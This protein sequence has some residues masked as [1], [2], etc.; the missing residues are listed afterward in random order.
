MYG[1]N[2]SRPA[3]L[4]S[5]SGEQGRARPHQLYVADNG[6]TES[7]RSEE[8]ADSHDPVE[9]QVGADLGVVSG[10][11]L[12][13]SGYVAAPHLDID[14]ISGPWFFRLVDGRDVVATEFREPD[15]KRRRARVILRAGY[16]R[17]RL[18][19]A[20]RRVTHPRGAQRR[21]TVAGE[22]VL[23][24]MGSPERQTGAAEKYQ[25]K[26]HAEHSRPLRGSDAA[27]EAIDREL[28]RWRLE[29][30]PGLFAERGN[31]RLAEA[32]GGQCQ[33][34]GAVRTAE[35]PCLTDLSAPGDVLAGDA[36]VATAKAVG[37]V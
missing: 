8:A 7:D 23:R 19:P 13:Q 20:A 5:G 36:R 26:N 2:R 6:H 4:R 31:V 17:L 28:H 10:G 22:R 12:I 11:L 15:V 25:G 37:E 3:K 18:Q 27:A 30:E 24:S 14:Q 16:A 34:L 21:R 32:R 9:V 29:I 35:N 33:E 1:L